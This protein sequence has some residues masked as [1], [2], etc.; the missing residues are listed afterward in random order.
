MTPARALLAA[1]L[2]CC[3]APAS[4]LID[5]PP[6]LWQERFFWDAL[7]TARD[8][9]ARQQSDPMM[10]PVMKAIAGQIA[11]QVA[12]LGQID[13]YVK[14][15]A[16]NLRFAY[17]QPDPK[18]SLATIRDNFTTLTTGCDQVRQNLYYLTARQRL[19]QAQALPDPEMYQAA[20]L[21][22]GQIQQLQLTLNAVYYDAVAIRGQVSENKWANDKFFTHATEELMRS[23]VRVQD[24]V[25]SVY[26]A[27]YE[28]AMR[29]R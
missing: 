25:F 8:R 2:F 7:M 26:N 3:A 4:A 13:Q 27:G 21:I 22:L 28:L 29:C 23:V 6:T 14:A 24:S 17:N 20:L 9:M 10:V 5:A 16:D 12:N 1:F 18:P 15:Q 19:A 11:Q